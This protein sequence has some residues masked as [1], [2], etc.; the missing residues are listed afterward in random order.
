MSWAEAIASAAGSLEREERSLAVAISNYDRIKGLNGQQGYSLTID[1]V[2]IM[3][4]SMD[5]N[6]YSAKLIRGREMIHLG[7]LKALD[8]QI[9]DG[10]GR[11]TA[12]KIK[13][14]A[15]ADRLSES[16]RGAA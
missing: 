2:P 5:R 9:D 12:C 4:A 13:L 11:V 6:T 3:V 10:R 8:S 7:V 16:V 14:A 15:L 1:G